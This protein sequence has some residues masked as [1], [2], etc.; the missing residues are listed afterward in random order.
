MYS[1]KGYT[2]L[3]K[4]VLL[5]VLAVLLFTFLP[6]V[7]QAQNLPGGV[8]A[9][10][11]GEINTSGQPF[12]QTFG[13]PLSPNDPNLLPPS[14]GGSTPTGGGATPQAGGGVA[15]N[16]PS[17]PQVHPG[18]T[19]TARLFEYAITFVGRIVGLAG[20]FFDYALREFVIGFGDNY[21]NKNT[22]Y[23][24]ETVWK[25]V[26]DVFN[27]TFIFGIIYIGFR[28]ILNNDDSRAKSTLV[29]LLAA[30]LLVNF[31]LF[32]TKFIIDFANLTAT[33][34]YRALPVEE[35][36]QIGGFGQLYLRTVRLSTVLEYGNDFTNVQYSLGYVFGVILLFLITIFVL[37][38]GAVLITIRFFVLLLYM[39]FSPLMFL[40]WVFPNMAG[41]TSKWWS[42]FLGKAFFAPAY[43]FMLYI[44]F[45]LT[46]MYRDG[47]PN[48]TSSMA[49]IFGTVSD[50]TGGAAF[51]YF[52][53]A[54][55]S[56]IA[57]VVIAQKM[58]ATGASTAIAW[59]KSTANYGKR[60]LQGRAGSMTRNFIDNQ[61]N[62]SGNYGGRVQ[63]LVGRGL[64]LSG[65]R[66]VADKAYKSSPRA[67]RKENFDRRNR[68]MASRTSDL[69]TKRDIKKYANTPGFELESAVRSA[70]TT[71]LISALR[72]ASETEHTNIVNS[73]TFDQRKKIM[74][75]K[76]DEFSA[77]EKSKVGSVAVTSI[78][79]RIINTSTGKLDPEKV[80]KLTP[81]EIDTLGNKWL[82]D[83]SNLVQL[84]HSL[85]EKLSK[86]S[87][88]LSEN[89]KATL[90]DTWKAEI[91]NNI[92]SINFAD[93][94]DKRSAKDVAA[95]PKDILLD[96][97]A[98]PHL[99]ES[100]LRE[101]AT[102]FE[103]PEKL[104]IRS[105]IT[106]NPATAHRTAGGYFGSVHAA[107]NW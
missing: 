30:A 40:G 33:E 60:T 13:T 49:N 45:Y 18:N 72:D 47:R 61:A 2:V 9:V 80:A 41:V 14:P 94:M 84:P 76:D 59:G 95:L 46:T 56:M 57:S 54:S 103:A 90:V 3:K 107:N 102:K 4:Y 74:D 65:A 50:A 16:E 48:D 71:Q 68:E 98:V 25:V 106:N 78:T 70:S 73:M 20:Y 38:A 5:F 105:N 93:I 39:I 104:R 43:V 51:S 52:A 53:L 17:V 23:A 58:G 1:T 88:V 6:S 63:R 32:I 100:V 37:L 69:N 97:K 24:V 67:Q 92:G 99:S 27:L 77:S 22:G 87:N 101:L 8:D 19:V 34:V 55:I 15:N 26:R 83:K 11:R 42:G 89:Q 86:D 81:K 96:D 29:S 62:A 12:G 31:S 28:L 7:T 82:E 10:A 64:T 35:V 36:S 91:V 85:V 21:K 44:T 75:A 66:D 79:S